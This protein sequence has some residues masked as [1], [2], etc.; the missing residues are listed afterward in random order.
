M[1]QNIKKRDFRAEAID[2]VTALVKANPDQTSASLFSLAMAKSESVRFW[3]EERSVQFGHKEF[4]CLLRSSIAELPNG[5]KVRTLQ[6]YRKFVQTEDGKEKQIHLWKHLAEMTRDE[7]TDAIRG[8]VTNAKSLIESGNAM[9]D[10]WNQKHPGE[11]PLT[12]M[13]L[14]LVE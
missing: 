13:T 12:Q 10:Y 1:K 6:P 9:A 7:A 3:I 14:S 2:A 11:P 5:H 8:L 4:C